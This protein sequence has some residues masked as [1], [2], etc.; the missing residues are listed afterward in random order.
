MDTHEILAPAE[1]GLTVGRA[2]PALRSRPPSPHRLPSQSMDA[3]PPNQ[4]LESPTSLGPVD[5]QIHAAVAGSPEQQGGGERPLNVSD[6]L[7]YL[8]SVKLQFAEQPEVYN[9]FLDI[10]KDF[11]SQLIDTPGVIERVSNLFHG[12]PALI[13]GF[14]TF[15]PAGYR[16]ET[17]DNADPNTITV[18]T[19]AG[20]TT[21]ATNAA[22][23]Y[24]KQ[25]TVTERVAETV[26]PEP[27]APVVSQE[28]LKPALEFVQKLRTRYANQPAVYQRFLKT[29]AE[30]GNQGQS[31]I[32]RME[33]WSVACLS[34]RYPKGEVMT[35][36]MD[37]LKDSPDLM[38][39][40][41]QFLPDERVQKE[42]LAR[43]ARLEES[44]KASESK[45]KRATKEEKENPSGSVA[46]GQKR[47]RKP[48]GD[49]EKEPVTKTSANKK[50]KVQTSSEAPSPALAQRQAAAA[51]P[52]SPIRAPPQPPPRAFY[53]HPQQTISL[54]PP[55]PVPVQATSSIH[56]SDEKHFF[57][58]VKR[59]LDNRE[60]YNEFLKLV[61][62]FTQDIINT[63]RLVREARSFIGD[64]ELMAQFKDILGWDANKERMAALE[65][66]WTRPMGVLD[67]PSRH[68]LHNRYGS[69]RKLPAHEVNVQC[70][71]RDEMCNSVL[72]DE[73]ISQ[74]TF[75]SEDAGFVAPK[76]NVY[77][78]ALHRSEEERHE[79]DFHVEAIHRTI[80]VLEPLNNKILQLTPEE[81]ATFKL[82]PNLGGVG[83][84]IHQRVIKKIYGRDLGIEVWG[85]MQ[86]V[87]ATAIP[88]VLG[89]LKQKHE[90]WKR[91]Q[92]E[93]DKVWREVDARNYHKSLDHQSV[94]F[95][96]ADKKA[97]TQKV[98]VTQI[99]AARDEQR[100]NRAALID[101]LFAR[102]KPRH[103]LE[104]VVEDPAVLQ[105]ALKLAFSFLDRTQAQISLPDRRKIETFLRSFVPL[106]FMLDATAFNAAFVPHHESLDSDFELEAVGEDVEMGSANGSTSSSRSRSNKKG[107]GANAAGDLRKR[108]LKSEQ[109]KSSR[110]TR[111][112]EAASPTP[113]RFASPVPSDAMPVD[114]DAAKVENGISR[115]DKS[116][117]R[118][119]GTFYT[120]TAFY[121]LLRLLELLYTR[122]HLFKNLTKEM[123][124]RSNDPFEPNP[125]SIRSTIQADLAKL[126]NRL[127]QSSH[128]YELMLESCEK[129]FDNEIEQPAFEEM[130]RYMFGLKHAY[131]LFT[132]DKV[133]G[134]LIKQVQT[135]L[136]DPKSQDLYELLRRERE[137]TSPTTQDLINCR[138]NTER[139]LGPDE[140]LFRIDWLPEPKTMT[141]QLIGKDDVTYDDSEA[142]TGRW[143]AYIE[144]FVSH[145]YTAGVPSSST[146]RRPFLLRTKVPS[147]S[148]AM[149]EIVARGG[150]QIK[151]CVRTYRLFFVSR[152]EDVMVRLSSPQERANAR[153]AVE[154]RNG[155]RK[156]WLEDYASKHVKDEPQSATMEV[157]PQTP[158]VGPTHPLT[159]SDSSPK[160]LA[161]PAHPP[162]TKEVDMEVVGRAR[163]RQP[164]VSVFTSP[165]DDPIEAAAAAAAIGSAPEP[166][167]DDVAM[168]DATSALERLV[169]EAA[170]VASAM[171]MDSA[172]DT[173]APSAAAK[174]GEFGSSP[175]QA[176]SVPNAQPSPAAPASASS[177]APAAA[178]SGAAS[179]IPVSIMATQSIP[180]DRPVSTAL[181]AAHAPP[182]STTQSSK[183]L[184]ESSPS[185]PTPDPSTTSP[186]Q[187]P[188]LAVSA[189]PSSSA[190]SGSAPRNTS[191][192]SSSGSIASSSEPA[193]VSASAAPPPPTPASP[194]AS[195]S[196]SALVEASSAP[197]GTTAAPGPP[198]PAQA[199][200]ADTAPPH[201]EAAPNQTTLE[202]PPQGATEERHPP[203]GAPSV[204]S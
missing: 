66:S 44:R 145:H 149:P 132:V 49:K 93:W 1:G 125:S 106:F 102:T 134:A 119:R 121:V 198:S 118:R 6:A 136:S 140:N 19:P 171:E 147:P 120:N 103:Q 85:A 155:K 41:V 74:P 204:Q 12:H 152:S 110:R 37:L 34:A 75:Q 148:G 96:A 43:I 163:E 40:F 59:V 99:E 11:K 150:L 88:V 57:E 10:M 27:E 30:S 47:K 22:F 178:A 32:S 129:L 23:K 31:D 194:P 156:K 181:P 14:N 51:A 86:E 64:G 54:A 8:D 203:S 21:Q 201:L 170:P 4:P 100:V 97:I 191:S 35:E 175:G 18:T 196:A 116:T 174:L 33:S 89:R 52:P 101:P 146:I 45:P 13:Q 144:S 126:G 20:T 122:L 193:A 135:I 167:P 169:Q 39:D 179:N 72:N 183:V 166:D 117:S 79:Y 98:F 143:Q 95:K 164:E 42:E 109:A 46:T 114:G 9:K 15:L 55:M 188:L 60:T 112:Q 25:Q 139:V 69:Y 26:N 160:P 7:S 65:E 105:D 115:L 58:R 182:A 24:G 16:I 28:S 130:M 185:T 113:S 83:K 137:I 3:D 151:V 50:A 141:I 61:N 71:G 90:E 133:I 142:M 154:L 157:A 48:A 78:E 82:K 197:A 91:A 77:E 172:P 38:R 68:Q 192:G 80:Q 186:E 29:L 76:K 165:Q 111:A 87:P 162:V 81:R 189:R 158:A 202:P 53:L 173:T 107:N 127:D 180:A 161:Q 5:G 131:K 176:S 190:W 92:R 199:P 84:A 67:R 94:T 200:A 168:G 2:T 177:S 63:T 123:A 187:Q 62:L 70:S 104:F 184:S 36:I 73:W 128:Y 138:R 159:A 124:D 195:T 17:G 153:K 108:L 56:P